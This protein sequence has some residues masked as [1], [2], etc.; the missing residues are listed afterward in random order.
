MTHRQPKLSL[1]SRIMAAGCIVIWAAGVS[2]CNVEVLFCCDAHGSETVAHADREHLHDTKDAGAGTNDPHD[3]AAH[4]SRE[5]D[6]HSHDSP[7]PGS[8]EG[9][10]CCSTLKAVI[11]TS[12]P[13]VF[14]QPASQ[15]TPLFLVL[16]ETHSAT[17]A[18]SRNPSNSHAKCWDWIFTPEVCLG[19][20]HRSLAP[21]VF[22]LI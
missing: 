14:S 5:A 20:A 1:A 13:V 11:L 2:A 10:C 9:S 7:M 15:T 18:L 8:R 17:A 21:P 4:H 22:H 3:V 19:P 16:A 12:N 6:G